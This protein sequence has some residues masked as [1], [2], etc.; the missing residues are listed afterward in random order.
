LV[1]GK[2]TGVPVAIIRGADPQWFRPSAISEIVRPPSED[3]FR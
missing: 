2:S 1:M 3:L